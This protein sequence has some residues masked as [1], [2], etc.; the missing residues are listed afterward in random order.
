MIAYVLALPGLLVLLLGVLCLLRRH[1]WL[2]IA[3]SLCG[4][5]LVTFT[6]AL[7]AAAAS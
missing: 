4:V 5:R 2:G 6:G 3:L 1:P 7:V